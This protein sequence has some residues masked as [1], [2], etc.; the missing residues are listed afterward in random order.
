M[1]RFRLAL[2]ACTA[3]VALLAWTVVAAIRIRPLPAPSSAGATQSLTRFAKPVATSDDLLD[4]AVA[5]DPFQ[6][7]RQ[8][9]P[10]RYGAAQ[11]PVTVQDAASQSAR[12]ATL[13]L[14]GTVVDR[15]GASFALCQLADAIVKVIHAGQRIGS[16][17]LRSISPGGAVFDG[18]DGAQLDLRVPRGGNE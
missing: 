5:S 16:Y 10:T 3:S 9:P 15:D 4:D 14:I 11:I 18:D 13:H 6:P 1:M 2:L 8:A 17:R 7:D 12:P